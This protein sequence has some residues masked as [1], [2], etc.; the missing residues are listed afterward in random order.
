M[1]RQ[2]LV[3]GSHSQLN[4]IRRSLWVRQELEAQ[5]IPRKEWSRK[6]AELEAQCGN[7]YTDIPLNACDEY[8]T[9][10]NL[11]DH[12]ELNGMA[13]TEQIYVHS[14][15]TIVDDRYVLVGSANIND[16]SLLGDRD[17]ELAVLISDTEYDYTDIDGSGTA[18]PC[19]NFARELRQKAWRK[20]LGS[21]AGEC[22]EALDKPAL[23]AGWEKI[24]AIA[25]ANSDA[26]GKVFNYIP[27]DYITQGLQSSGKPYSVSDTTSTATEEIISSIWPVIKSNTMINNC[28]FKMPFSEAFWKDYNFVDRGPLNV[29]KGYFTSLTTKWSEGENNLLPYNMRLIAS[30]STLYKDMQLLS[31]NNDKNKSQ[32]GQA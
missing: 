30:N 8:V 22:A 18:V 3:F 1:T 15:L 12:E 25:S 27:K 13:V 26:Y 7:A 6:I 28:E 16:R 21:A 10:L 24:Q 4:R 23:K 19:R 5:T 20:W 11:R 29:V 14:K 32:G 17:S 31:G 2:S 9:L